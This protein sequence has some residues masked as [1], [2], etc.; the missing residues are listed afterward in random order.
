MPTPE[1]PV[2]PPRRRFWPLWTAFVP[3]VAAAVLSV[4]IVCR[5]T[6]PKTWTLPALAE[7]VRAT[8]PELHVIPTDKKGHMREGFYLSNH[9]IAW[10]DI[11]LFANK[12]H[13]SQRDAWRGVAL[14]RVFNLDSLDRVNMIQEI[15][16][17][18]EGGLLLG[19]NI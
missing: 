1:L 9:P 6:E 16:E 3:F 10:E 2:S 12:L 15:R 17:W 13:P 8:H 18:G 14:C 19:D 5:R 4:P 11:S 7:H